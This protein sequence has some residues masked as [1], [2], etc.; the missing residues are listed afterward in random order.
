MERKT[1]NNRKS[2][3]KKVVVKV[4]TKPVVAKIKDKPIWILSCQDTP[5]D[6]YIDFFSDS[7]EKKVRV[8]LEWN[9]NNAKK[10]ESGKKFSVRKENYV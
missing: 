6:K 4:E 1:K 3:T 7:D 8:A 5:K 9:E 2:T 10:L